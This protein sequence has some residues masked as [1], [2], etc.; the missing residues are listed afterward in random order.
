MGEGE[1]FLE[2]EGSTAISYSVSLDDDICISTAYKQ[3][4]KV[5]R[6]NPTAIV[7][8]NGE[9]SEKP[10]LE[11]SKLIWREGSFLRTESEFEDGETVTETF[12]P[13]SGI[14]EICTNLENPL[15]P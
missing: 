15:V 7:W 9:I 11:I 2:V 5:Y 14:P 10:P 1:Y 4:G 6:A 3:Q 12:V 8:N 13:A